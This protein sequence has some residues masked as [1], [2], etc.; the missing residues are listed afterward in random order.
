MGDRNGVARLG[1]EQFY[2]ELPSLAESKDIFT[3]IQPILRDLPG[4]RKHLMS[5]EYQT[6]TKS[7]NA[8][9]LLP[10]AALPHFSLHPHACRRL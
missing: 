4:C 6:R 10:A 5:P 2:G 7:L 3:K 1:S 8:A 9:I